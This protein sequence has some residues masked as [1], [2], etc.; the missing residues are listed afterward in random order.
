MSVKS[1]KPRID[2]VLFHWICDANHHHVMMIDRAK[3]VFMT[4]TK[5]VDFRVEEIDPDI[6]RNLRLDR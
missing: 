4:S 6:K 5:A 2:W 1:S 3:P